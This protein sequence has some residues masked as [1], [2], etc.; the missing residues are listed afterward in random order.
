MAE[1][2][3]GYHRTIAPIRRLDIY[4]NIPIAYTGQGS[5]VILLPIDR[6]RS[7]W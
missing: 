1:L 6:L 4:L 3:A 7:A 5:A 2:L